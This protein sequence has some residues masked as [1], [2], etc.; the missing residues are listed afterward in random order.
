LGR[1]ALDLVP[2]D[3]ERSHVV[4][5]ELETPALELLDLAGQVVSVLEHDHVRLRGG[6][7]GRGR[8]NGGQAGEG[9]RSERGSRSNGPAGPRR[10]RG[11]ATTAPARRLHG[12]EVRARRLSGN[13]GAAG[14]RRYS[15]R[16]APIR[17][18]AVVIVSSMAFVR[19]CTRAFSLSAS[20]FRLFS[21]LGF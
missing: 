10:P 4:G 18:L 6:L 8:D 7:R 17:P 5:L 12:A 16:R 15:G 14:E 19:S 21:A 9:A 2:L 13:C 1:D 20:G 11:T 3:L